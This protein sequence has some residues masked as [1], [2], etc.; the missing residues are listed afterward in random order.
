[1]KCGALL[2]LLADVMQTG[3]AGPGFWQAM[4]ARRGV[5]KWARAFMEAVTREGHALRIHAAATRLLDEED[6]LFA[7]TALRDLK[8]RPPG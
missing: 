8:A 7:H 4:R 2:P 6:Y 5:R 3:S 1:M